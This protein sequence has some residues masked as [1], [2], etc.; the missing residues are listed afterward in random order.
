MSQEHPTKQSRD[1]HE[2]TLDCL[3]C[4]GRRDSTM[5]DKA[6]CEACYDD[7]GPHAGDDPFGRDEEDWSRHAE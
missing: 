3:Y 6:S 2:A 4:S 1:E 7:G 5:R